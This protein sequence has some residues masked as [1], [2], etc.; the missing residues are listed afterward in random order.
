M[1]VVAVRNNLIAA[2]TGGVGNGG[3]KLPMRKLI[4]QGRLAIGW[5]GNFVDGKA[6]ADW[7]FAGADRDKLPTFHNRN[8]SDEAPD[9]AALLLKPGGWEYWT[10]WMMP[11]TDKDNLSPYYAIGSGAQAA[12]AAMYMDAGAEEAVKVA[13]A[14]AHGCERPVVSYKVED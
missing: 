9:F 6:F 13:C 10:E 11:E 12:M 1:S 5:V 4:R 8:G 3:V 14:V 7:Y 2:D